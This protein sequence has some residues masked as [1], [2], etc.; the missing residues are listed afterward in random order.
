MKIASILH[1]DEEEK[2][3][4]VYHPDNYDFEIEYLPRIGEKVL[5]DIKG[6]SHIAEVIDVHHNIM[7]GGVDVIISKER[8]REDYMKELE[9]LGTLDFK[10][11]LK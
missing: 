5:F 4:I 8:L 10:T 2:R 7:A 11:Q 1:F 6:I 9:S 3:Y